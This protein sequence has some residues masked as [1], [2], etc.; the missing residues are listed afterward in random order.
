MA[1]DFILS[2]RLFH[3]GSRSPQSVRGYRAAGVISR[4]TIVPARGPLTPL[5][6]LVGSVRLKGNSK[7]LPERNGPLPCAAE[8]SRPI[9][10]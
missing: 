3:W 5:T 4:R 8:K 1:S 7:N 9:S 6:E 2:L 10:R